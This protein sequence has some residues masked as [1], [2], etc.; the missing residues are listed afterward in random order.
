M[1][2]T[3]DHTTLWVCYDCLATDVNGSPSD[4]PDYTPDREP[5]A[6]LSE[7]ADATMGLLREEHSPWCDGSDDC[8]CEQREFSWSRCDGCGSQLGGYR[9]AYTLWR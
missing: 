4:D 2:K 5:W 8:G 9:H 1:T 6:E 3:R 7:S